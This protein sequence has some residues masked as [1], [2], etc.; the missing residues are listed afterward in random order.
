MESPISPLDSGDRR[1]RSWLLLEWTKASACPFA[2]RT[3]GHASVSST[4]QPGGGTGAQD[5]LTYRSGSDPVG[6]P[7]C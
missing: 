5:A 2:P 4:D 1:S 7:S 6:A 3:M